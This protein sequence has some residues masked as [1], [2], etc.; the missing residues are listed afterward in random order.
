MQRRRLDAIPEEQWNIFKAGSMR[1]LKRYATYMSQIATY[2][3]SKFSVTEFGFLLGVKENHHNVKLAIEKLVQLRIMEEFT[4]LQGA[5]A[6]G[7]V[8]TLRIH[9]RYDPDDS[10]QEDLNRSFREGHDIINKRSC[11]RK[12]V[13]DT[14]E[15]SEDTDGEGSDSDDEQ[16]GDDNE[17]TD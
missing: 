7:L 14:L 10:L 15:E 1:K 9:L 17:D 3:D 8:S 16:R 12:K 2:Y 5:T 11:K 6:Y 4:N 13:S